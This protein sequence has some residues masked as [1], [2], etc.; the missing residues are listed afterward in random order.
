YDHRARAGIMQVA[1]HHISP[2]KKQWTW[3]NQEFGYAWDRNLTVP[4]ENGEYAPYIELMSGVYT[5]NQ[6]DFAYLQ[7]GETKTWSQFWY[8]F[9][10]IGP[11]QHANCD[12]AI[13]LQLSKGIA[14]LGVAVTAVQ[15]D[16][17]IRLEFAGKTIGEW[18]QTIAPDQPITFETMVAHGDSASGF[19]L[20]VFT[21]DGKKLISYTLRT[22]RTEAAPPPASEPAA[23]AKIK[24][25]DELFVIGL[26]LEQYRHATR[27]P[28]LY[29]REALRRD[30]GDSRCTL[31]M[32]RWHL[33]RGEFA[34]AE[35]FLRT[36]IARQ[37]S[38]NP[39][40]SDGEA[41]YQLGR[42][43]RE[44]AFA[45]GNK[46][47]QT[48]AGGNP[49]TF[50]GNNDRL[51]SEA[52]NAFYKATWNQAWQ[53]A[54][55]HA[56]AEIDAL[57]GEW[58][59]ALEHLAASLRLNTDNLRA[60]NL[61][62]IALRQL[63]KQADA[64]K[65]LGE[66]LALDPLDWWARFLR[67]EKLDCD[68]QVRLDLAL[69]CVHAG[70]FLDAQEI[71]ADTNAKAKRETTSTRAS[72]VDLPDASLGTEPLLHYYRAWIS[73]LSGDETA[74]RQA[75]TA[76]AKA[77]PDHCFPARLE[78]I[79]ILNHA[80]SATPRD[81]RAPFL[82][83]NLLYDRKRHN[84]AIALWERAAKLEPR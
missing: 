50:V 26:H 64:T 37:T 62:V 24:S 60:R 83:G 27:Q 59:T 79:A 10:E 28:E 5:D 7:P 4:D 33:R 18:T 74:G 31:A 66:T 43:L 54:G 75:L 71:L 35:T 73:H 81:A 67:G 15:P 76:A 3:G 78:E 6:P 72:H 12:A 63:G 68:N 20:S 32:G 38:R 46:P 16:A 49:K 56:L 8:P 84:E 21:R 9:R 77:N 19:T 55:Y 69:D 45:H 34:S 61:Q 42:C 51:L 39:N 40:P 41:Y 47:A 52:Y 65:L 17:K 53:S 1:N 58:A 80:L 82:L 11:A 29:W 36:S 44:Q 2:G 22:K 13:S 30:P 48:E 70:L 25:A 57:R 23:P 14:R